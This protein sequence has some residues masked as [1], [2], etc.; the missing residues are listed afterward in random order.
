MLKRSLLVL[1]AAAICLQLSASPVRAD[2][3]SEE[4]AAAALAILGI[5]ALAHNKHHYQGGYAPATG[6]STADFETCYRRGLHGYDYTESSRDCA[7]GWQAGNTERENN[8]AHQQHTAAAKP[9]RASVNG[10]AGIVAQNFAVS[11]RDVHIT[12]W[13]PEANSTWL[14]EA[15]VGHQFMVCRM[16]EAGTVM[17]L[18]G[19][20]RL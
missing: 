14:I 4:K 15:A 6:Q 11:A 18:R 9:P 1:G 7:Q 8:M 5:V 16:D 3:S 13:R 20:S 12:K 2:M 17:D 19:G 10:C